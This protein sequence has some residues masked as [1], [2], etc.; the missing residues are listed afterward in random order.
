MIEPSENTGLTANAGLP[1]VFVGQAQ[2]EFIINQALSMIDAC[3]FGIVAEARTDPPDPVDDGAAFLV[4]PSANGEWVGKDDHLALRIADS[5]IFIEPMPGMRLFDR[6]AGCMR[7]FSSEW[8]L[9]EAPIAPSGG[10]VVDSEARSAIDAI[11]GLL[12]AHGFFTN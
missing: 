2:K 11:I 5:W 1:L 12:S 10:S 8:Q 9:G 3:L 6:A 4:M 7:F